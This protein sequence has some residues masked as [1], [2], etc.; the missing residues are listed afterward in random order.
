MP[1]LYQHA[2]QTINNIQWER[3]VLRLKTNSRILVYQPFQTKHWGWRL[4][5]FIFPSVG[6]NQQTSILFSFGIIVLN[7]SYFTKPFLKSRY[8]KI[9]MK[10]NR[11]SQSSHDTIRNDL[12]QS[13]LW[14]QSNSACN[15][16]I[17]YKSKSRNHVI[18]SSTNN[19]L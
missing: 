15:E 18:R 13:Y 1:L 2:W 7:I 8:E 11:N 3:C 14:F 10:S 16:I 19:I 9:K 17:Q 5:I 6:F 12:K 4:W